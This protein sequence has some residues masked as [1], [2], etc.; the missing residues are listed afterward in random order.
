MTSYK[1]GEFKLSLDDIEHGILRGNKGHPSS[2]FGN[3]LGYWFNERDPRTCLSL[4]NNDTTPFIHFVLVC[5]AVSCPPITVITPSLLKL[6]LETAARAFIN[7]STSIDP[8]YVTLS[9]IFRWYSS[10]FGGKSKILR[11]ILSYII[12]IKQKLLL[13][14]VNNNSYRLRYSTYDWSINSADN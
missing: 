10:D 2:L 14:L 1:L 8:P 3:L 12:P 5:G 9:P 6:Q 4:K 13:P 7:S 11:L